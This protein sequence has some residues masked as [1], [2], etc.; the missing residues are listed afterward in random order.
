MIFKR[1]LGVQWQIFPSKT[2][3]L[4]SFVIRFVRWV[5]HVR[6]SS[7]NTPRCFTEVVGFIFWPLTLKIKCLLNTWCFLLNINISV[8]QAF[9]DNLLFEPIGKGVLNVPVYF[10]ERF[11]NKGDISV[12]SKVVHRTMLSWFV[13]IVNVL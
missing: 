11:V 4:L 5:V 3:P 1:D 2:V 13:Q 8:L 10:L 7:K 6:E 12:V 9:R